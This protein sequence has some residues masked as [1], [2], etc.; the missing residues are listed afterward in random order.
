MAV[1]SRLVEKYDDEK[2]AQARRSVMTLIES[3]F[4]F[5]IGIELGRLIGWLFPNQVKD[6]QDSI[7]K[8]ID[9]P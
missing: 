4:F 3:A 8:W 5:L 7:R 6:M 2:R 1:R 9:A